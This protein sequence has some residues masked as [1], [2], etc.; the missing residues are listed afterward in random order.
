MKQINKINKWINANIIIKITKFKKDRFKKRSIL[1][2]PTT[3]LLKN[4]IFPDLIQHDATRWFQPIWVFSRW[5]FTVK[6]WRAF[7]K[8]FRWDC[9]RRNICRMITLDLMRGPRRNWLVGRL[10]YYDSK[11]CSNGWGTRGSTPHFLSWPHFIYEHHLTPPPPM[12]HIQAPQP[13]NFLLP[14]VPKKCYPTCNLSHLQLIPP[15]FYPTYNLS[16]LQLI[17]PRLQPCK[18]LAPYLKNWANLVI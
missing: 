3:K 15:A 7:T 13:Y 5:K 12:A 6:C 11:Q 18:V 2:R 17:P 1:H 14:G 10:H 16:H 9:Y 8:M 4:S